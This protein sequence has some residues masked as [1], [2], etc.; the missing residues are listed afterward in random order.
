M[1]Q[2]RVAR[3]MVIG[4]YGFIG[5]EVLRALADVGLEIIGLGRD[6]A[7]GARMI[8]QAEWR[9][10]DLATLVTPSAWRPLIEDIDIIVNASGALQ[11]APGTSLERIQH[12]AIRACIEAAESSGVRRFVQISAV[13]ASEAASTA[14]L[15]T[16][17]KADA[18]LR[19]ST[20][21]WTILRPGLVI[22][23]NAYGGTALLRMLA[24]LPGIQVLVLAD[25]QVQTVAMHDVTHA[26]VLAATGQTPAHADYDLVEAQP[27]TLSQVVGALRQQL[28]FSRPVL[29]L[30]LPLSFGRVVAAAADLAGWLGWR[31]ALRSTSLVTLAEGIRGNA[32]AWE[33]ASGMRLS[34]LQQALAEL[35]ATIQERSFARVQLLIPMLVVT[36]G[37]FWIGTGVIALLHIDDA[38]AQLDGVVKPSLANALV[39]SGGIVDIVIGAALMVR[40]WS[41]P[42]A[43]A[44]AAVAGVYLLLGT[45]LVPALWLDPMGVYLKVLP[46]IVASAALALLLE[47]R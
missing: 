5:A 8:S 18:A 2:A 22:G 39:V 45:V 24:G 44:S 33:A 32:E 1:P 28:G 41:R 4:G 35:P 36:L 46:C 7:F 16:K 30:S 47:R 20:L 12:T 31:P 10:A 26:V 34:M 29:E 27:H 15:R 17:A 23:R 38:A 40:R 21:D 9:Q 43:I 37:I 25:A 6:A 42:A 19:A 14:F 13:G 11:D 3:A